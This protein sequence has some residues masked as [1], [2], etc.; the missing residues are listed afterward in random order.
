MDEIYGTSEAILKDC[1]TV[2]GQYDFW[3]E[4]VKDQ[5]VNSHLDDY[6]R[7]RMFVI[8]LRTVMKD[9]TN[10]TDMQII[11]L[12]EDTVQRVF[13]SKEAQEVFKKAA[14]APPANQGPA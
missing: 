4:E 2:G 6:W 9:F 11:E 7:S 14:V 8:H 3:F 12:A 1:I 10:L 13:P 5:T